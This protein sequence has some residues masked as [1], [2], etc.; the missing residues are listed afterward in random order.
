MP[1]S[2]KRMTAEAFF[3][4]ASRP[5]SED[6]RWEWDEGRPVE[7]PLTGELH[8]FV[9]WLAIRALTGYVT[10]RG[11][12]YLLTN[13]VGLV[14]GR[15]P[16]TV[17]GPDVLLFPDNPGPAGF[18]DWFCER[19]PPLA[20]EVLDAA[21]R[22]NPTARRVA[23]L[24]AGGVPLVWVVDPDERTVAAHRPGRLPVVAGVDDDLTGYDVLPD[25][26]VTVRDLFTS[27]GQP[28][29]PSGKDT[30]R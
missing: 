24:L 8:G 12:G 21:D 14:L 13:N 19:V 15:K 22:L 17:R 30:A 6:R 25:L 27:P 16:D 18:S 20:V 9:C 26:R 4:W 11:S 10:A 28:P 7:I 29:P 3:R 1:T 2:P 5:E 23:Q